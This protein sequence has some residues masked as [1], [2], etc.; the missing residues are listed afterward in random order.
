MINIYKS[1]KSK[2]G[3]GLKLVF[4]ITQ[5]LKDEQIIHRIKQH[6]GGIGN[7]EYESDYVS[8][9][10]YSLEDL[11]IIYYHYINYPLQ[12]TKRIYFNL[13]SEVLNKMKRGEHKTLDGFKSIVNIKCGLKMGISADLAGA[14]PDITGISEP[15]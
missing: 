12:T 1:R 14:F 7:I 11:Y 4:Q 5:H 3:W 15:E 9:K 13:W 10:A 6:F 2:F 8:F